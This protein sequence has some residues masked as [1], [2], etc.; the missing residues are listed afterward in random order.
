MSRTI[1]AAKVILRDPALFSANVIQIPLHPYQL[2]PFHALRQSILGQQGREFL[3]VMPRQ[4]GKNEFVAH[5][6][7]YLLNLYQFRTES[8]VFGAIGDGIGR[9]TRRLEERLTNRWNQFN[10]RK[11]SKPIRRGLGGTN[12]YFLSTHPNAAARGETATL[13]LV[14]DE[15]QDND[16][17]HLETVFEPM[18]AA[19]NATALYIGTVRKTSDALWQKK[20]QLERQQQADG[21]Q[22]VF[23]V[24]P[25]EVTT[26]NPAYKNFLAAKV[27]RF[28]RHHPIIASEYFLEP[29]DT[30]VTLFD[31]RRQ[32]LMRGKHLRE[33][34]PRSNYPRVAT[35][36]I[37]GEDEAATDPVAKLNN[38]RRDYTTITI[39]E[40]VAE[41]WQAV[42]VMVDQGTKHFQNH[43]GRT[44]LADQIVAYLQLWEVTHIIVDASGIGAGMA[45]YLAEKFENRVTKFTFNAAIKAQL[46]SDFLALIERGKFQYFT[47]ETG[48]IPLSDSWWFWQQCTACDFDLP[49]GGRFEKDL[50]W[51]VPNTK[52]VTVA[53]EKYLVHDD[54]L[55]SAALITIADKLLTE[56]KLHL[57]TAESHIIEAPD[58]LDTDLEPY[59][60]DLYY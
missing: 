12:V 27:K 16:A 45:S 21:I 11:G 15:L 7:V 60:F 23:M 48:G 2:T 41:T 37:G 44:N 5:L 22:R 40:W 14:I 25:D 58:P 52:K 26:C 38:P 50:K 34:T 53:S 13:L 39:F 28:G 43:A 49:D 9:M 30:E 19:R 59:P 8:V 24:S 47:E 55:L 51:G 56:Q 20:I 33:H 32:A 6:L 31:Q 46:G 29:I 18:R 4:A 54:R 42:D 17:S 36:D 10:W 3:I 35:I 57:G 1:H